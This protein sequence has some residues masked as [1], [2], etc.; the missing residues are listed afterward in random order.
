MIRWLLPSSR[1]VI[2]PRCSGQYARLLQPGNRDIQEPIRHFQLR[3]VPDTVEHHVLPMGI[4]AATASAPARATSRSRLPRT[5][6]TGAG[7]RLLLD[8]PRLDRHRVAVVAAG[9][10]Q[11]D[12]RHHS[13]HPHRRSSHRAMIAASRAVWRQVRPPWLRRRRFSVRSGLELVG[14]SR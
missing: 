11:K 5:R 9:M 4:A 1:G 12:P 2:V 8:Q 7:P 6:S 10:T 13:P 14:P 3:G